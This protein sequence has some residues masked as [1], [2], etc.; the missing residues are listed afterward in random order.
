[1]TNVGRVGLKRTIARQRIDAHA[2][3]V[4]DLKYSGDR[5]GL[6]IKSNGALGT[7]RL[8]GRLRLRRAGE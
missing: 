4:Q 5:I 1:M 6:R 7:N 3:D 2:A 8:P